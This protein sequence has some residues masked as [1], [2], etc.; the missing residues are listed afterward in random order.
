[1]SLQSRKPVR[2]TL[3]ESVHV[4]AWLQLQPFFSASYDVL[5]SPEE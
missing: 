1:M 4:G 2:V 5:K 3:E